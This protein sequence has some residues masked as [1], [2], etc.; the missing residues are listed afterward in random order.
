MS[1][2]VNNVS[3]MSVNDGQIGI[4]WLGQAGFLFKLSDGKLV[5]ADP[6]FSDCCNRYF[7]FKRLMPYMVSASD[8]EYDIY[9]SS[10]AHYDH[11]DVD[12]IGTIMAC[13]KTELICA[14]DCMTECN[15][16]GIKEKITY[17]K[18]GDVLNRDGL[19]IKAVMCDHG[20]DTPDAVG[21]ILE[22]NNKKIYMMGDT[23]YREDFFRDN[24]LKNCDILILPINGAFG[25]LNEKEA[26]DI[27]EGLNPELTVPC[28]FWNFAE[29]GG[30]PAIFANIMKM[31]K[32]NY[33][34]FR[35][36]EGVVL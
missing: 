30:N 3:L 35:M 24:E 1:D 29:H 19:M 15:R 10:H 13:P 9:I 17:I 21:I 36:G 22:Y 28:H 8:L 18:T 27:A 4:F 33:K 25:N 16:L 32:L 26:A 31:K 20:K 12:S 6:Y 2:F 11:F 34:I 7:G 5:V 14:Y 23:C